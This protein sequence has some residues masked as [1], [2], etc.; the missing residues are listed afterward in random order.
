MAHAL[1]YLTSLG[2]LLAV[3]VLGASAQTTAPVLRF[4]VFSAKP[5]EGLSYV[6]R[7]GAPAQKLGFSTTSRSPVYEYRGAP[8]LRLV[9]ATGAVVAEAVVPP[10]MRE[11]LL[12]FLPSTEKNLR[13]KIAVLDDGPSARA[14]G[15]LSIINLSGFALSGTVGAENV[16]LQAGLN[17]ALALGPT[18][19]KVAL[20]SQQKGK[21]YPSY[22]NTVKLNRGER[23]LLILFPPVYQ[24]SFEVSSRLL[25]DA[26]GAGGKA[27]APVRK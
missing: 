6:P 22:T 8:P 10:E 15:G 1:R 25:I 2:L 13:Y 5:I 17:P 24:G 9:D 19:G 20:V 27:G 12:L 7:A 14:P 3:V 4:T 11:A 26:P 23:G 18:G 21:A 16:T